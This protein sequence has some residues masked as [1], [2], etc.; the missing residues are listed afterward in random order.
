MELITRLLGWCCTINIGLLIL[1]TIVLVSMRETVS[2][3]HARMFGLSE[4]EV[5]RQY[6]RYLANYKTLIIV[7]NLT[8]YVV[9]RV[10][11]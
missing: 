1:A 2:R 6:F 11:S 7:F 9:L 8:P 10:I 4:E 5:A 3:M